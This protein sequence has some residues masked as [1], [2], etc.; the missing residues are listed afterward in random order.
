MREMA[1]L[2]ELWGAACPSD[3]CIICGRT[4]QEGMRVCGQLICHACEREIVQTDVE[5]EAYRRYVEQMKLI[6]LSALSL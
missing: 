3:N 4:G 5:D 2:E 6:W 1:D